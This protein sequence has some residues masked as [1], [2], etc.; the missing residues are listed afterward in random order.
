MPDLKTQVARA[1]RPLD[2]FIRD[3]SLGSV[4]LFTCAAIALILANSPLAGGYQELVSTYAKIEIGTFS[5]E[6]TLR[7][8]VNDGLM[9]LFFFVLGLEIK[10]EILV[11]E[12]HDRGR[13][14]PVIAAAL[15][16]MLVPALIYVAF[17]AG[18]P[19]IRGWGVPMATDTAFVIGVLTLIG[20]EAKATLAAFL[21]A[22]AILD[23]IGA[24]LVIAIFYAEGVSVTHLLVA[25]GVFAGLGALNLVGVRRPGIYLFGGIVLWLTLLG[26]GVHATAAGILAA[27][28]TPARPRR[29]GGWLAQRVQGLV[30]EFERLERRRPHDRS[31]L[32][33]GDQHAVVEDLQQAVEQATTPL[34]RWERALE[35]PIALFVL[36]LFAL[37]N[38]GLPLSRELIARLWSDPLALGVILG[39]VVGKAVGI[40]AGVWVV[41]RAGYGRLPLNMHMEHVVGVGLLGGMGFTMSLYIASLGLEA[42][43]LETAK[44]AVIAASILAGSAGFLWLR[45]VMRHVD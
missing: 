22:L 44:A 26:S 39:L 25:A 29:V 2:A 4:I 10:R 9:V 40:A 1:L 30:Q 27:L 45:S 41:L 38:A 43:A 36:P 20:R 35:R 5:V 6:G 12:L 15:G 24:I 23:D 8:W 28:A 13:A 19:A 33:D 16:G 34:Q 18:S 3:A 42:E 32:A 31:I 7:H 37:M 17:N 14:L 11:G 21:T